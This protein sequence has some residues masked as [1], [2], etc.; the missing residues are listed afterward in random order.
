[1][2]TP[3]SDG[4]AVRHSLPCRRLKAW[5]GCLRTLATVHRLDSLKVVAAVLRVSCVLVQMVQFPRMRRISHLI[6][7]A[8]NGTNYWDH[9]SGLIAIVA[10]PQLARPPLCQLGGRILLSDL[11]CD[12]I[13][14][15]CRVS[16]LRR[17]HHR[18]ACS[19]QRQAPRTHQEITQYRKGWQ[20]RFPPSKLTCLAWVPK[21]TALHGP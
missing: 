19:Q 10:W 2:G 3:P 8:Q 15:H 17:I 7:D 5:W 21:L 12:L 13:A 6:S 20:H 14:A 11:G 1:M 16:G 9:L 4:L 18:R